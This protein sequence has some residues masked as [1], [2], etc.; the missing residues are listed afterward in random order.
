MKPVLQQIALRVAL[1]AAVT[2]PL[3]WWM[4]RMGVAPIALVLGLSLLAFSLAH[5]LYALIA[6]YF[7]LARWLALR[8]VQGQYF[9]FKGQRVRVFEDTTHFR[10]VSV[11]D[12]HAIVGRRSSDRALENAFPTAYRR[13]GFPP[14]TYL[15]C[16]ALPVYLSKSTATR[17]LHFLHW[18]EREIAH[19]ARTLRARKFGVRQPD[20]QSNATDTTGSA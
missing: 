8:D 9:A 17:T 11:V 10:W 12:V 2:Y 1:C 3:W 18:V 13:I 5:P 4:D 20:E 6:E 19:P 7:R 14:A 16:E 15:H